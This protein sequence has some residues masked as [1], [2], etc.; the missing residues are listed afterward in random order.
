MTRP[1]IEPNA[2][3]TAATPAHIICAIRAGDW[4]SDREFDKF[5]PAELRAVSQKYWTQLCVAAR[6]AE[7][8]DE[9]EIGSVVD[10]GSGSGKFCVAA[11]LAGRCRFIGVEQRPRLVVAARALARTF[12]VS[13]RVA[14]VQGTFPNTAAPEAQAYYLYNPFGENRLAFR[15]ILDDDVELSE[16]R[17]RRDV[18]AIGR[19]LRD[20]PIGTCLITYNGYGGKVPPGYRRVFSDDKLPNV[21]CLWR[22]AR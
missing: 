6:A 7:W 10:I 12:A 2:H 18:A 21:L 3:E 22:K 15:H 11:A 19:L 17:Y 14:F 8:L 16:D 5:L 20:A 13:H 9:L 4:P 1:N